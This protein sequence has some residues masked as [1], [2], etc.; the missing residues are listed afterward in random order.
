VFETNRLALRPLSTAGAAFILELPTVLL[1]GAAGVG[2]GVEEGRAGMRSVLNEAD[3]SALGRRI[4]SLTPTSPARWGRMSVDR[5]LAHL[6]QSARMAL[7]ELSVKPK[8]QRVFQVF[9]LKHLILYVLPFPKGAPT[10][11]ELLAAP[12]ESFAAHQQALQELIARLG[13]GTAHGP[14]PEHP[15][16]GPLTRQEWGALVHKHSDHHLRQFGA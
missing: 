8:G 5:M 2:T 12:R 13:T 16:F 10:A 6:G 3:R 7:G 9:P 15:L 14:G 4:G 11:P 1:A